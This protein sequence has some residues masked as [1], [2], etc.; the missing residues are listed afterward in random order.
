M[1]ETPQKNMS[2]SS[3]FGNSSSTKNSSNNGGKKSSGGGL[4]FLVVIM[5]LLFLFFW[6]SSPLA[7]SIKSGYLASTGFGK[8]MSSAG[9]G[10]VNLFRYTGNQFSNI[11]KILK[12]EEVFSFETAG[13]ETKKKTGLSFGGSSIFGG[14]D[15]AAIG[16]YTNEEFGVN[17]DI[18]VG[19]LDESIPELRD[20]KLSCSVDDV[21]GKIEMDDVDGNENGFNIPNPKPFDEARIPFYCNFNPKKEPALAN[22]LLRK[23]NT[24]TVKLSLLYPIEITSKL[25]IF[26]LPEKKSKEYRGRYDLAFDELEDG[27]YSDRSSKILSKSKYESDVDIALWFDNQP[28]SAGEKKEGR[29]EEKDYTLRFAVKNKNSKNKF[30]LMKFTI[31]LPDGIRFSDE[32]D[33]FSGGANSRELNTD[34]FSSV[35]SALNTEEGSREWFGSCKVKAG[36]DL[37]GGSIADIVKTGDINAKLLY[38][39]TILAEK[40]IVLRQ[41]SEPKPA[42]SVL[43]SGGEGEKTS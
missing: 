29:I 26:A 5:V 37:L 2:Q 38:E 18:V 25:E 32:C 34:Y 8:V 40:D 10:F 12:G 24:K 42:E 35:N 3:R 15:L 7:E 19:K 41:P 23:I 6:P 17:G 27:I 36:E 33:R 14:S 28:L 22:S 43:E 39:Y 1:V 21:K 11:N 20:V 13:S 30:R 9:E 4:I 16:T 31:D